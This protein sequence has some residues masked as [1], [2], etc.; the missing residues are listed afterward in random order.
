[1]INPARKSHGGFA[2]GDSNLKLGRIDKFYQLCRDVGVKKGLLIFVQFERAD[3]F[4]KALISR[5]KRF[6]RLIEFKRNL[7]G[8]AE[9]FNLIDAEIVT[10]PYKE[11]INE[12][13]FKITECI[14]RHSMPVL[15][16]VPLNPKS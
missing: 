8:G 13:H 15:S 16:L 7:P 9:I 4:Q 3:Y 14:S 1:M 2:A 12:L 6:S 5:P 11:T 10:I